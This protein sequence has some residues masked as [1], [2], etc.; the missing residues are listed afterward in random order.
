M[1]KTKRRKKKVTFAPEPDK[2]GEEKD[3]EEV[4]VCFKCVVGFAICVNRGNNAKRGFDKKIS[5]G[6]AF[7]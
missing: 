3:K 5:E 6:L 7:L 2:A 4:D 1:E